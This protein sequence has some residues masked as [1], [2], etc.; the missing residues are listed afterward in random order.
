MPASIAL[1]TTLRDASTSMFATNP[2]L[3]HP[4]PTT[5]TCNSEFP[6]FLCFTLDPFPWN[7]IWDA[8]PSVPESQI[9]H[10][11]RKDIVLFRDTLWSAFPA[12]LRRRGSSP[13]HRTKSA[14]CRTLW[15]DGIFASRSLV[16]PMRLRFRLLQFLVVLALFSL[17]LLAQAPAE[18]ITIDA[19]APT[20]PFP[21]F[22]EQMF[23]SGRAILSLRDS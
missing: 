20:H 5:E 18:T 10:N 13:H 3:L 2:K 6:S 23:G 15:R 7:D 21:H 9:A 11:E 4:R 1:S 14:R 16:T 17:P 22:W 8:R 12:T 19:D